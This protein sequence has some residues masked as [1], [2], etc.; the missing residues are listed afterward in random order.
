MTVGIKQEWSLPKLAGSYSTTDLIS[1]SP[2]AVLSPY[3]SY[4]QQK[5]TITF[6]E[7][8]KSAKFAGRMFKIEISLTDNKGNKIDLTDKNGDA[9][10]YS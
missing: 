6:S 10:S 8:E 5:N 9:K 7:D 1:I 3:I 4:D 2:A